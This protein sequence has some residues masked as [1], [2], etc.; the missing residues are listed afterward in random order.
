MSKTLYLLRHAKSNWSTLDLADEARPLSERGRQA[1]QQLGRWWQQTHQPLPQWI[2]CSSAKRTQDTLLWLARSACWPLGEMD[3]DDDNNAC[4]GN[5]PLQEGS[6]AIC[7]ETSL[8]L[9]TKSTLLSYLQTKVPRSV[10]RLLLI[11]HQPGIQ[12]LALAL[13]APHPA[14]ET[15]CGQERP[16]TERPADAQLPER[17]GDRL[18]LAEKYPTGGLVVLHFAQADHWQAVG[19]GCGA[20]VHFIR[21][22]LLPTETP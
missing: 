13:L 17:L 10:E 18:A 4:G 12:E 5:R 6:P 1:S 11:A 22:R 19:E 14:K 15:H 21:P 20:L 8:Y 7:L 16:D 3:T 2:A 9:A